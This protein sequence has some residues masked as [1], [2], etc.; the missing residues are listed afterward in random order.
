MAA[1]NLSTDKNILILTAI[2]LISCGIFYYY[3]TVPV[4]SELAAVEAEIELLDIKVAAAQQYIGKL[5]RLKEEVTAINQQLAEL[6]GMLPGRRETSAVIRQTHQMAIDSG[7][8]LT[9][10][11]PGASVEHDYYEAWPIQLT[12]EGSFHELGLFFEKTGNFSRII[13]IDDLEIQGITENP[14]PDKTIRATCKA[15]TYVYIE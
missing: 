11:T 6:Q 5:T 13:S 9:G 2:V 10:F 7:L 12:M 1:A 15:N 3:Y 14:R 8:R 4:K